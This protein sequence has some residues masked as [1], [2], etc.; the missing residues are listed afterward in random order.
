MDCFFN[1]RAGSDLYFWFY[2]TKGGGEPPGTT[3]PALILED[4]NLQHHS[5]LGERTLELRE[6]QVGSRARG[7][8]R[9]GN[10]ELPKKGGEEVN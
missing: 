2:S 1:P 8:V 5:S 7:D 10:R 3:L 6:N 9:N 4:L